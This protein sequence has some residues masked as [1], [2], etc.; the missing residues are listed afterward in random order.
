MS[1][2]SHADKTH[3]HMKG[4]ARGL[5]LKKRRKTIRKWPINPLTRKCF[6]K[7]FLLKP[8]K[9]FFGRHLDDLQQKCPKLCL[10]FLKLSFHSGTNIQIFGFRQLHKAFLVLFER[11]NDQTR[12]FLFRF[13]SPFVLLPFPFVS[14][15]FLL[16]GKVS[17]KRRR[18]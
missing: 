15:G 3:F 8:P 9:R 13:F 5:S 6:A 2:H 1:F 17:Q 14:L 7:K 16:E 12:L 11:E 10:D 18:K 4:F